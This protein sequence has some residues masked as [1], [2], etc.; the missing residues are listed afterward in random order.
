[1]TSRH[2]RRAAGLLLAVAL[3]VGGALV[4]VAP[5]HATVADID[6]G[7]SI[8]R[9]LV[10]ERALSW[11]DEKVPYSQS[12]Y[13]PASAPTTGVGHSF[14]QDCSGFLSMAWDLPTSAVTGNFVSATSPY[15]IQ[16]PSWAALQPG[17]LLGVSGHVILFLGWSADDAGRH[18]YFDE[19]SE[20]QTGSPALV[21]LD[22]DA[23]G[24]WHPYVPY[25]YRHIV[26]DGPSAVSWGVGRT[27]QVS[28]DAN[29]HIQHR[30]QVTAGGPWAVEDMTARYGGPVLRTAPT[31]A[32]TGAGN[33][34]V[35]GTTVTGVLVE[36]AWNGSWS[37]TSLTGPGTVTGLAAT[38]EPG[39]VDLFGR[40]H[41]TDGAGALVHGV[42][43]VG[44]SWSGWI[45]SGSPAVT[46]D[47]SAVRAGPSEIDIAVEGP[48]GSLLYGVW[49]AS[50][51]SWSSPFGTTRVT[52]RPALAT[53]AD[54]TRVLMVDGAGVLQQ[55]SRP[56]H[57]L[58]WGGFV[59][60]SGVPALAGTAGWASASAQPTASAS[61]PLDVYA[62]ATTGVLVHAQRSPAGVWRYLGSA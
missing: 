20:S 42:V 59:A 27:D 61:A 35:F 34:D 15:D 51:W 4:A 23:L 43:A 28:T 37:E 16:L 41:T 19:V 55:D 36:Y 8:T 44:R 14:R 11:V 3:A 62:A 56:P 9:S 52:V 26:T 54:G 30:W 53:L 24:Y 29:G 33:L 39:R 2:G 12:S 46:D 50:G 45:S 18:R 31:A 48:A 17:D 22:Q 25:R 10:V 60:V 58:T 47:A 7:T 32:T 40:L 21:R 57:S 1:M 49:S 13:W 38:S 5:A 6:A